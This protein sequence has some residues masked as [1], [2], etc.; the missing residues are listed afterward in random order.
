MY[1]KKSLISVFICSVLFIGSCDQ[2]LY[3]PDKFESH[4]NNDARPLLS[5]E[6][7]YFGKIF[8][9]KP[10]ESIW[11][12][13]LDMIMENDSLIKKNDLVLIHYE[14]IRKIT[15][16]KDLEKI[17]MAI[18]NKKSLF[19][20][21]NDSSHAFSLNSLGNTSITKELERHLDNL[22]STPEHQSEYAVEVKKSGSGMS[23]NSHSLSIPIYEYEA[24]D[25]GIVDI[26]WEYKGSKFNTKCL[27]SN[28]KGIIYDNLLSNIVVA[29]EANENMRAEK[30]TIPIA[31]PRLKSGSE[32]TGSESSTSECGNQSS[33]FYDFYQGFEAWSLAGIKVVDISITCVVAG[34]CSNGLKSIDNFYNMEA[35]YETVWPNFANAAI[36]FISFEQGTQGLLIFAWAY[37][38]RY[39]VSVSLGWNGT[40]FTFSGGGDGHS[41]IVSVSPAMLN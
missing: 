35:S 20:V 15:S 14:Y 1:F 4:S 30:S 13:Q 8:R 36:Q 28:K 25:M 5:G 10:G 37:T 3:S 17:K 9:C 7:E 21:Y 2:E 18:L 23:H 22:I 32:N 24:D 11:Q 26:I 27:V 29:K 34:S 40:G 33:F 19:P 31:T 6:F 39:G 16:S 12:K 38:H 41:G